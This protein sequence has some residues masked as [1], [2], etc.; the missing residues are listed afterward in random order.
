[1]DVALRNLVWERAI[2]RCE[3]CRMPQRL[4]RPRF[5]VEHILPEKH[6]GLTVAGNLAL[7]CFF[8]NRF[9]GPNLSGIDPVTRQVRQLFDP[10]RNVWKEHF[11]WEGAWIRGFTPEGRATI[12]VLRINDPPRVAFRELL[13]AGGDADWLA[14][15]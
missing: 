15:E 8:C 6:G 5:E 4:D 14:M 12:V 7:A 13:I 10:R 1:M 2:S 3:Y 11:F 9:K